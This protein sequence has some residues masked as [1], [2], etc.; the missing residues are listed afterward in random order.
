MNECEC[1]KSLKKEKLTET[2]ERTIKDATVKEAIVKEDLVVLAE[3]NIVHP[4]IIWSVTSLGLGF[5]LTLK[6]ST[7]YVNIFF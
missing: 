2:Y 3:V 6:Q 4:S 1:S 5:L 7:R